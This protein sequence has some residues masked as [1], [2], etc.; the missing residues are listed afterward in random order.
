MARFLAKGGQFVKKLLIGICAVGVL[1]VAAILVAPSFIDWNAHKKQI[2]ELV[3]EE[4]GRD[5]T[6][7]GNID[8]TILPSPALRVEDVSL[9]SIAGAASPE[10]IRL[11]EARI[12]IAFAPLLEGRL[13]TVVTLVRPTVNLE[14]LADG[15]ANW[16]FAPEGDAAAPGAPAPSGPADPSSTNSAGGLPLDIK[17]DSF[18]IVDGTIGY[19]DAATNTAERI[20]RLNSEISFDS[21]DG[22]FRV[23]GTAAVRGVEMTLKAS[24]GMIKP[25]AP[26]QTIIQLTM[27]ET[28]SSVQLTGSVIG[29]DGA[30]TLNGDLQVSTKNAAALLAASL[31]SGAGGVLAQ[32]L[33]M[34]G[35]LSASQER[36]ALKAIEVQFGAARASGDVEAS[37]GDIPRITAAFRTGNLNLDTFLDGAGD[38]VPAPKPGPGGSAGTAPSASSAPGA[39]SG[40][41]VGPPVTDGP[42]SFAFPELDATLSLGADIIQFNGALARDLS[43]KAALADGKLD[44]EDVSAIL[45]GNTSFDM[46]GAIM[47]SDG[48]P[49]MK[50]DVASRS[51]NI[52]EMLEWVGVDTSTVPADR[53]RRFSLSAAIGG[54]PDN[55]TARDIDVA[56]DA[57]KMSGGLALV[58]RD[59]PAFGLR[60]VVDRVNL[61]GYLGDEESPV[62]Q[63]RPGAAASPGSGE[64]APSGGEGGYDRMLRLLEEFDA[65]IDATVRSLIVAGTQASDLRLDLTVL[66]G[67]L[68]VREAGIGDLAGLRGNVKGTLD[69]TGDSPAVKADYEVEVVDI[70]RFA[71]F[72]DEPGL[73][74]KKG[75]N[76]IASSGRVDGTL[77]EVAVNSRLEALGMDVNVNGIVTSLLQA[78][79][80]KLAASVKSPELV[81]VARLGMPDYAPAAGKLG[82]VD[83]S[84]QL[85]G[86]ETA[87]RAE[88]ISGQ[89]GPVSVQGTAAVRLHG[90]RPQLEMAIKTSEVLLDLFLPPDGQRRSALPVEYRILPA[91]ASPGRAA[92]SRWSSEAIETA[93]LT[94][95]DA[96]VRVDM[97]ALS[98]DPYRLRDTKLHLLLKDGRLVLDA[99][100]ATF[101]TGTVSATGD[102]GAAGKRLT[103]KLEFAANGVDASDLVE[104][105]KHYQVRLGPVRFGAKVSGPVTLTG[106]LATA[107]ASERELV[108]GLTG[109]ARITGQL[110]TDLSG[111]TRQAGAVAGLAGALLG[112][113][114]KELRGVTN[115]V[116]G[117]DRLVSAFEGASTL[118]GDIKA[119]GGVMTT[120]NLVLVGRG[121]RALTTATANLSAWTLDSE[122]DVTL[123]QDAE[124]YLTAEIT[125]PLDDAYVRK[126][127]GSLL[128]GRSVSTDST[129][130]Q[131]KQE[132]A[133]PQLPQIFAPPETDDKA[134]SG[135]EI[136]PEDVFR[137]LLQGLGR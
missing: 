70:G 64:A 135:S 9:S 128:R 127:S 14:K 54:A 12:S 97:A 65:N 25:D 78:P 94:A 118:N 134:P 92:S 59:R 109:S 30:P 62:R 40:T 85:E 60:V 5:L 41:A 71:R 67:G 77:D 29:L 10:M 108:A 124:P 132:A 80:Y 47:A 28:E 3:R 121:G 133:E 1:L 16:R 93:F 122:T 115:V 105:L 129:G 33:S 49:D 45:P 107:G 15:R 104:A 91:A 126:V 48:K 24:A 39:A 58:M 101:S 113:K 27:P 51:D 123:G 22:P 106:A 137:G 6:I 119:D 20:E 75:R 43:L 36:V 83:L 32:P 87:F 110:R 111:E 11:P 26:L 53:L 136:K 117:T 100:D 98:K 82:P 4:T 99:F 81:D 95:L 84:F 88:S 18:R 50:L 79:G 2:S 66:N 73:L 125:G 34:Q 42:G 90:D 56:L 116:Q 74:T 89:A 7:R 112:K 68:E 69:R 37:I 23:E 38:P 96:D 130:T 86:S 52:R 120:R 44:I 63:A 31:G 57:T 103:G 46:S 8:V 102:L 35:G 13:A 76:R 72:V 19:S 21:L 114:V 61:D 17:L 55:F 131:R